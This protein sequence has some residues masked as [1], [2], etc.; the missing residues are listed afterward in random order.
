LTTENT[1]SHFNTPTV[2]CD[3]QTERH[4]AILCAMYI[5][6]KPLLFSYY[7]RVPISIRSEHFRLTETRFC[8]NEQTILLNP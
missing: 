7:G 8:V 3:R 5:T 4:Q 2:K 1:F 6:E